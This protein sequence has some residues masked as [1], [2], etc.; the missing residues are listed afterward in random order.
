M[1]KVCPELLEQ[2]PSDYSGMKTYLK[3]TFDR[4]DKYEIPL[5]LWFAILD[6]I[7]AEKSRRGEIES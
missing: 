1:L 7:Q 3:K 4:V 5:I 6:F 2:T